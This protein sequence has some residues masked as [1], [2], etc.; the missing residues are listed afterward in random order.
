VRT[1]FVKQAPDAFGHHRSLTTRLAGL[2]STA[3]KADIEVFSKP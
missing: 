2:S 1:C 3:T